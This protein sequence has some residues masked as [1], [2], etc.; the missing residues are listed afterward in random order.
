MFAKAFLV[1]DS[2][3]TPWS[4][5]FKFAFSQSERLARLI[6]LEPISLLS[7]ISITWPTDNSCMFYA[8]I[9]TRTLIVRYQGFGDYLSLAT[10][11][12]FAGFIKK[13]EDMCR[14]HGAVWHGWRFPRS[15]WFDVTQLSTTIFSPKSQTPVTCVGESCLKRRRQRKAF[16]SFTCYCEEVDGSS[17]IQSWIF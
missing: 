13:E 5:C 6:L 12:T 16:K 11:P 10:I 14:L 17:G 4:L 7:T 1:N 15:A 9:P 2:H 3:E 8:F